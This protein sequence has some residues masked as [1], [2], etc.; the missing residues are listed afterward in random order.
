[1]LTGHDPDKAVAANQ[2]ALQA[3]Q[4]LAIVERGVRAVVA[5]KEGRQALGA[6]RYVRGSTTAQSECMEDVTC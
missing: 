5:H 3:N 2:S 6:M 4:C 1:V